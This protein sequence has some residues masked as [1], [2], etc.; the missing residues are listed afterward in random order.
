MNSEILDSIVSQI[1]V[2]RLAETKE[3][4]SMVSY[5]Q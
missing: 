5:L 3:I 1:P 2:G 4:A